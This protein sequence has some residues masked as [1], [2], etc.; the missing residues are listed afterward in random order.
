MGSKLSELI[1][2]YYPQN[3]FVQETT[4]VDAYIT[5]DTLR[6]ENKPGVGYGRKKERKKRRRGRKKEGEGRRRS[7]GK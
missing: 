2:Q 3:S 7:R 5:H 1:L 6:K 4:V